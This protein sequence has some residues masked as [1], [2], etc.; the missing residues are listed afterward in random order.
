[1]Q[2]LSATENNKTNGFYQL[3]NGILSKFTCND[4][5]QIRFNHYI[6]RKENIQRLKNEL[7]RGQFY[8]TVRTT[9]ADLELSFSKTQRLIKRFIELEIID[10]V[11]KA[12]KGSKK[13]SIYQYNSV[14][15]NYDDNDILNNTEFDTEGTNNT[16][17][18]E[19]FTDTLS[20]TSKKEYI[21]RNNKRR[22]EKKCN[23]T[24]DN[25]SKDNTYKKVKI[26]SVKEKEKED[27]FETKIF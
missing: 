25:S 26:S 7:P 14:V 4:I 23:K 17:D 11:F 9:S 22:K 13:P 5:D 3:N 12:S 10:N 2:V 20:D 1:M 8:L 15:I 21:K 16:K 24:L 6:M 27:S 18:L 19:G